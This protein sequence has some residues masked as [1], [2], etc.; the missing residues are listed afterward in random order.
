MLVTR[1]GRRYAKSLLELS[2]EMG[3]LEEVKKDIDHLVAVIEESRDFRL[4]VQS[5]VVNADIK[6][7]T[8]EKLF[9]ESFQELTFNFIQIITRKGREGHL[10]SIAQGFQEQYNK[11]KGIEKAVVT[12]A[13]ALS[14]QQKE[15]LKQK[16]NKAVGKDI[17]IEEKI[18]DSIIGGMTLRVGDRQYNGSIAHQLKML[19]RQLR[20]NSYIKDF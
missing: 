18:D 16:L 12:T 14:D 15:E 11:H 7:K 4:F 6:I 5:P 19:K 1:L 9:K 2:I 13:Q 8:F 10:A 17:I 20:D 3:K